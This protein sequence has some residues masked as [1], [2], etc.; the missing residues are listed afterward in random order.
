[1]TLDLYC[2]TRSRGSR[3]SPLLGC[4]CSCY[5]PRRTAFCI[6]ECL[7]CYRVANATGRGSEPACLS[8]LIQLIRHCIE[9]PPTL[10]IY[11]SHLRD[12]Y[13]TAG[14]ETSAWQLVSTAFSTGPLKLFSC[15][16][17]PMPQGQSRVRLSMSDRG[18]NVRS[19]LGR[20]QAESPGRRSLCTPRV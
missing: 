16:P 13:A 4:R 5:E 15:R 8:K 17:V 7:R 20:H 9:A 19:L 12:I 10:L 6:N 14:H 1:V 3:R 18:Q 2:C 11:V